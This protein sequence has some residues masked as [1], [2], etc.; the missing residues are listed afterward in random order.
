MKRIIIYTIFLAVCTVAVFTGCKKADSKIPVGLTYIYMP[1]SIVSG[2]TTLNYLVPTGLDTNTYNFRIDTRN[3][4]VNVPLGVLRSGEQIGAGY[5]VT[6]T[7]RA[8]TVTQ[9]ISNGLIKVAPN[10]TKTVVLL[11]ATAYTLPASVTVPN[12]QYMAN[13]NLSIDLP[14]LKTYAGQKVALCVMI[15]NASAYTLNQVNN[16]VV[17]IID[18]DS[19]KLP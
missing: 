10:A 19:L 1:Q 18:V 8:D 15:S 4:K 5:T 11:P 14:T 7:T 6:I 3:N 12:N 16:K 17:I 9:L 13:F 2:G